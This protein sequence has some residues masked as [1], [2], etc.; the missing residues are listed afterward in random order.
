RAAA[1]APAAPNVVTITASDFKFVA[2]DTVPAG[3]TTFRLVNNGPTIHHVQLIQLTEG[4]T[5]AD[6]QT[7][8]KSMGPNSPMP[9]W[10]H[11]IGGPNAVAASGSSDAT[12][13]LEAGNYAMLCFVDL[14]DK[15]PHFAKGMVHGLTVTPATGAMAAAPMADVNVTLKDY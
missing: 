9:T 13:A 2:P 1:P 5:F 8:M 10:V 3:T 14:P 12:I 6:F 7:G 15:V 11:F 4:K